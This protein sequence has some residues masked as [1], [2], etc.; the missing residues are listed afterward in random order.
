MI[1]VH[2]D[3]IEHLRKFAKVLLDERL[4]NAPKT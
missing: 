4:K 3:D 2:E 1:R